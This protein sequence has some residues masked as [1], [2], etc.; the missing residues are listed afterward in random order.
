MVKFEALKN[1]WFKYC[2]NLTLNRPGGGEGVGI[3]PQAGSSFRYAETVRSRK[4][5][6]CDIYHMLIGFNLEYKLDPL[7]MS[8][9]NGNAIVEECLV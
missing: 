5:K 8:S 1:S 3:L 4:L 2:F 9:C 7:D 6:L